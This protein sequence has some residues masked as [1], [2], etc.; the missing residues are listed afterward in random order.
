MIYSSWGI[1]QNI[2]KLVILGH[3]LSF[4]PLK[5][6]KIKTLKMKN[7][8]EISSFYTCVPKNHIHMMYGSCDTE[9]DIEFFVILGHFLSF[10]P[11]WWSQKSKLKRKKK[12]EKNARGY[13]PFMHTCEP[14]M[15]IIRYI[16]FLKYKVQQTEIFVN[17]GHF[18]PLHYFTRVP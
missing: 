8:L 13:Y 16:W 18:L 6:P 7:L 4:Y 17:L 15:K 3:F 9:R 10:Y 1:E 2:P 5:T 12:K 11:T 14:W